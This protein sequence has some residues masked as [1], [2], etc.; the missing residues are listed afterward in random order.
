MVTG[1]KWFAMRPRQPRRSDP[2]RRS[3]VEFRLATSADLPHL[4]RL[5]RA[6]YRFDGIPFDSKVMAPALD[7]LV[8]DR[9][10]GR[11]WIA[12]D[13]AKAVGYVVLTFNYDLE[14]GGFEG[15]VTDVF[16]DS[17][18][19]RSGLGRQAFEIIY[20]YCRSA[21]ISTVELQ[22]IEHNRDARKFYRRLGFEELP[23]IVMARD[24]PPAPGRRNHR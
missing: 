2:T 13:G 10:L 7:K 21:G 20:A 6:Y 22:V 17:R 5:A 14:F 11:V 9:S 18:Y 24:V 23:R 16:I 19:R 12:R 15:Y 4:L 3:P 8:Q 1:S